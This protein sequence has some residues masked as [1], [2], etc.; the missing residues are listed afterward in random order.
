MRTNEPNALERP[1]LRLKAET[2]SAHDDVEKVP[3]AIRLAKGEISRDAYARQL[4]AYGRLHA[5]LEER[6]SGG[7]LP[8]V[9]RSQWAIE[10][11][12]ALGVECTILDGR[13]ERA[14]SDLEDLVTDETSFARVCGYAY[15]LE[16]SA[17]GS[18]FMAPRLTEA[19]ALQPNQVRY[20]RGLGPCTM[21]AWQEMRVALDRELAAPEDY[22][23]ALEGALVF[24]G[25]MGAVLDA[26][27][28]RPDS[29][30]APRPSSA[31]RGDHEGL[32]GQPSL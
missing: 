7:T 20:Y 30:R 19:L 24:F 14:V 8:V 17:L 18:A 25:R 16:G 21:Q 32:R 6:T 3:F 22:A 31:P 28:S 2:R 23:E 11:A 10:D 26:L 5:A 1:S 4:I 27:D 15:V 9:S 29:L 12:A 13:A